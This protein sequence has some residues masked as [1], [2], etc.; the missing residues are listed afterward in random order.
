MA[1]HMHQVAGMVVSAAALAAVGMAAASAAPPTRPASPGGTVTGRLLVEGGPINPQ[2]GQ[3]P[4]KRPIPGTIRFI[5]TRGG[6]V[7]T[8]AGRSGTF[9]ARLPAET[10]RV[11]FRTPRILEVNSNGTGHQTWSSP[12]TVTITPRHTTRIILLSIVP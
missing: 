10:Y 3:Q 6:T 2:T 1:R 11:S 9:T 12:S 4:G 5:S 8:R 7:T